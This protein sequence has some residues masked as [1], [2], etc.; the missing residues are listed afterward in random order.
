MNKVILLGRLTKDP[1]IRYS[2]G[3][4]PICVSRFTVAVNKRFKKEGEPDADFIQCVAFR[5]L[6]EFM[7]RYF[8]KGMMVSLCGSISVREYTDKEGIRR[9]MT[10]VNCDEVNFG[11]SKSSFESRSHGGGDSYENSYNRPSKQ[12]PSIPQSQPVEVPQAVQSIDD[13]DDLPF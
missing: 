8:K 4:E 13:D 7:E 2:Q 3:S 1:E 12:P 11:E 10:E 6:A 5:K 9:W